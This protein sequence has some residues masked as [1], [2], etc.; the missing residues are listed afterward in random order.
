[1]I[2][3]AV[4][5]RTSEGKTFIGIFN[6]EGDV[7]EFEEFASEKSF[8]FLGVDEFG[9]CERKDSDTADFRLDVLAQVQVKLNPK[10]TEDGESYCTV[11]EF[12][13]DPEREPD[14]FKIMYKGFLS[15][16]IEEHKTLH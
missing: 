6:E 5:Y 4:V 2:E 11:E 10:L 7:E 14:A 13:E 9:I 8:E 15:Q 1:M 3:L 12:L 16:L